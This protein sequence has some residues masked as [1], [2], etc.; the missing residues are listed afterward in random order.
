MDDGCVYQHFNG[1]FRAFV[2]DTIP[3][4]ANR[5]L[6]CKVFHWFGAVLVPYYR[7]IQYFCGAIVLKELSLRLKHFS[8]G[9]VFLIV[10]WTVSNQNTYPV[11]LE[12][13]NRQ[14][15]ILM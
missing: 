15:K 12:V 13:L 6:P 1:T 9:V 7:I 4:T 10:M 14:T 8:R 11:E 5:F 3:K 2:G